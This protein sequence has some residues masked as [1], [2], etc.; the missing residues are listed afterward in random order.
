IFHDLL[1]IPAD[2]SNIFTRSYLSLVQ[3]S[4]VNLTLGFREHYNSI[5]LAD[6]TLPLLDTVF[7]LT[8]VRYYWGTKLAAFGSFTYSMEPFLPDIL[9]HGGLSAYPPTRAR[10]F[11]PSV[12]SVS[13]TDPEND[14]V[15]YDAAVQAAAVVIDAATAQE[16]DLTNASRYGNYA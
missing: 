15:M 13:W 8:E 16:Q 7:N 12:L 1:D 14:A 3:A 10:R 5:P 11:L 4:P 6:V 9:T 2:T